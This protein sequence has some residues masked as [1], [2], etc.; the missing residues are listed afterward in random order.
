MSSAFSISYLFFWKKDVAKMCPFLEKD[1]GISG[2]N[3][4]VYFFLCILRK[5][6]DK[7]GHRPS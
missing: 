4:R 5:G 1:I 3:G 2:E 7:K 6:L